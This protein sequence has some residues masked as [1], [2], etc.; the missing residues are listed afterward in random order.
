MRRRLILPFLVLT[1][2]L[3]GCRGSRS[4]LVEAELR[5]K[6]RQLRELAGERERLASLNE[7]YETSLR[8]G[9]PCPGVGRG[10]TAPIDVKDIQVGRGTGGIDEDNCQGDEGVQV[11]LVPR[12][13]DGSPVKATGSARV[14]LV[15]ITPEGLKTPVSTWEI[16][17]GYLKRNWKPGLL[18][19]GYYI[20]LPWQAVPP[21]E[22]LR[23]VVQFQTPDG[24]VFEGERDI[25]VRLP[26]LRPDIATPK[27][28]DPGIIPT[29]PTA[30]PAP[31]QFNPTAPLPPPTP[32]NV[33]PELNATPTSRKYPV[34]LGPPARRPPV[35]LGWP[36]PIYERRVPR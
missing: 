23:V 32:W 26:H 19:T 36:E 1:A 13:S 6:D 16:T 27:P 30:I 33:G 12:D 31:P 15:A 9:P 4:D 18:S 3:A 5:L 25:Q 20:A 35:E 17:S 22:K 7:A 21:S 28:P 11:V 24:A 29:T 34:E 14:T 2:A 8:G 10:G